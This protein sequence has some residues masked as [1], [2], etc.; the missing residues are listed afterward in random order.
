MTKIIP[1]AALHY[2]SYVSV[3]R[4]ECW[5]IGSYDP[6][7]HGT[8]SVLWLYLG[9][10]LLCFSSI[11]SAF[12]LISCFFAW[13][14]CF[15][16]IFCFFLSTISTTYH[17]Y[18]QIM[19]RPTCLRSFTSLPIQLKN[20]NLTTLLKYNKQLRCVTISTI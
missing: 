11:F 19:L 3:L 1:N 9:L 20:S 15:S 17:S 4:I 18:F 5:F 10:F 16:T 13:F 2:M 7:S 12:L 14:L 6:T 8:S